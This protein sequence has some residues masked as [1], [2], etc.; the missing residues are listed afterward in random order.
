MAA[1]TLEEQLQDSITKL[2]QQTSSKEYQ[3]AIKAN[4]MM[5][6]RQRALA[7]AELNQD[8]E[9]RTVERANRVEAARDQ[10]A[11][12]VT[13][14][15]EKAMATLAQRLI[16]ATVE[17]DLES[18]NLTAT[19]IMA[20]L[21]NLQPKTKTKTKAKAKANASS[22]GSNGSNGNSKPAQHVTN[23]RPN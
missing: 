12:A 3:K 2:N 18:G 10:L 7:K 4:T 14:A 11:V 9:Y 22:N 20:A 8:P 15:R 17:A 16:G 23:V 5:K 21:G 19:E 1:K 6:A 13:I